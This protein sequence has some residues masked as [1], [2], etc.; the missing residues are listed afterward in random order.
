M[1]LFL[2]IGTVIITVIFVI[3]TVAT[4]PEDDY[5]SDR[6]WSENSNKDGE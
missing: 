3:I 5:E 4:T 1:Y 2:I 6:D